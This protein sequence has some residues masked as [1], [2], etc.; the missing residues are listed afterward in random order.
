MA[1][2]HYFPA[3]SRRFRICITHATASNY[4]EY[5]TPIGRAPAYSSFASSGYSTK[6]AGRL[7]LVS[8]S[9]PKWLPGFMAVG[10]AAAALLSIWISTQTQGTFADR[11][12]ALSVGMQRTVRMA[13]VCL[14][15]S[16]CLSLPVGSG[17]HR[18]ETPS[19]LH[20]DQWR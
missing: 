16:L 1:I 8:P 14:I 3:P 2:R 11:I 19:S 12:V 6:Y 5:F 17:S 13:L 9:S 4:G 7:R 15:R 20:Q 10:V 18:R